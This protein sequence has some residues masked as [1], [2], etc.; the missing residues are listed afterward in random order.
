VDADEDEDG[1]GLDD[2]GISDDDMPYGFNP[3]A[4]GGMKFGFGEDDLEEVFI[5]TDGRGRP[6]APE[7]QQQ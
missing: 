5:S 4:P 3:F 1:S 7:C 2:E 6:G